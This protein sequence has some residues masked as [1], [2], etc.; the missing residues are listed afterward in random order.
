MR[1]LSQ[2]LRGNALA[3]PDACPAGPDAVDRLT[4]HIAA[5]TGVSH[6]KAAAWAALIDL[7]SNHDR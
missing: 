7:E 2:A 6:A 3:L 5:A 4:R 1:I